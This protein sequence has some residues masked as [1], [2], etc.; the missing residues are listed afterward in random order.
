ML[1]KILLSNNVVKNISENLD[2]LTLLI[3]EIKD[4]IGFDHKSKYHYLDVWEHTL[5]ALSYSSKNFTVRLTLLLHDIGKPHSYQEDGE[6]R[7][8]KNHNIES[9]KIAR[10]RLT[11]LGYDKSFVDKICY[12]V[13]NHDIEI[14]K[15]DLKK[16]YKLQMLR[17]EVQICDIK[18]HRLVENDKKLTYMKNTKKLIKEYKN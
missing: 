5:K 11:E 10:K 7:H 18:A 3:P 15:D 12:L 17:F 13:L 16:D 8:F 14:T 4:M 2:E 6:F 9:E 1:E